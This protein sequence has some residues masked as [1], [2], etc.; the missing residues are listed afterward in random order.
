MKKV[1]L[2]LVG[3]PLIV[4]VVA[5]YASGILAGGGRSQESNSYHGQRYGYTQMLETR[6][7]VLGMTIDDL[8][9]EI[10]AGKTIGDIVRRKGI[11]SEEFH[12]KMLAAERE[13]LENLVKAGLLTQEQLERRMQLMKQ[14]YAECNC[15]GNCDETC[16][17]D[18]IRG[19]NKIQLRRIGE[20]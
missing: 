11:T 2:A 9:K 1:T 20:V 7:K 19:R 3:I 13:R 18:H 12:Q 14:N 8:Q 16:D 6:A 5:W 4:G 17:K 15:D 10:D